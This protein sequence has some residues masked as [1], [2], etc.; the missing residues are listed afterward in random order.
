M[1][2]HGTLDGLV[3][4][5]G[6]P[7]AIAVWADRDGC[8]GEAVEVFNEADVHCEAHEDCEDGTRVELCTVEGGGHCWPGNDFCP[9]GSST[10]T[11]NASERMA[12][13]FAGY[14]LP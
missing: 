2:F 13:F 11:I 8:P 5:S 14:A 10:I 6:A 1:H 9:F 7:E 3:P 4:Y 12:E